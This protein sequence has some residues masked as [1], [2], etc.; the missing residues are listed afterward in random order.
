MD[1]I[2]YNH[3]KYKIIRQNL[4]KQDIGAEK[5]LWSKLRNKQQVF[6]FRRQQGI[7]RYVVDFYCPKLKL[8]IE[9]D[10]ATHSTEKEIKNDKE[11]EKFINRF[12]IIIRRYY[13]NDVYKNLDAVLTDIYEACIKR[14][15]ELKELVRN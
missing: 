5:V 11:R 10:G 2:V 1:N 7:G 8:A 4:R 6:K 9:I 15:E 3:K 13:N 14:Q 12:G